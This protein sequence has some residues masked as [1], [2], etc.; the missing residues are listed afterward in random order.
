MRKKKTMPNEIE[1]ESRPRRRGF[2]AFV[3]AVLGIIAGLALLAG[4]AWAWKFW[5]IDAAVACIAGGFGIGLIYKS[6]D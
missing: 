4:A 2:V 5:Q 1:V 6:L 3:I